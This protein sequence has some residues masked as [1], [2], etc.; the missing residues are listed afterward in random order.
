MFKINILLLLALYNFS[1]VHAQS[2]NTDFKRSPQECGQYLING[3]IKSSNQS[4]PT[5]ILVV[6]EGTKSEFTFTFA[7]TEDDLA[8]NIYR[9]KDVV[10]K[11]NIQKK[12]NGT[13]GEISKVLEIKKRIPNPLSS[14][15][16]GFHLVEK[17]K[18]LN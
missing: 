15:D 9:D 14:K 18:C 16:T 11:A 7:S 6:N 3:I 13:T 12:L 1:Q 8:Y 4:K 17:M 10:L 5:I 2:A